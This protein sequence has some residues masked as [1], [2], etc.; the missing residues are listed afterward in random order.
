MNIFKIENVNDAPWK[1]IVLSLFLSLIGL[2]ALNSISHQNSTFIQ[3]PFIGVGA[4]SLSGNENR[5]GSHSSVFDL[6]A[7][8]G[9]FG[10]LFILMFLSW[11]IIHF[12]KSLKSDSYT[13]LNIA[14]FC[15]WVGYFVGCIANPYF[16]SAAIDH[17]IFVVY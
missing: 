15:V 4:E 1:I 16:L 6:L 5:V 11:I 2:I 10:F 8:F 17:Y 12:K 9:V 13:N 7:Q 14:F 3:N